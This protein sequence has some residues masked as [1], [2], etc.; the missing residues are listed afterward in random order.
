MKRKY[1]L[2]VACVALGAGAAFSQTQTGQQPGQQTA[3]QPAVRAGQQPAASVQTQ[4]RM[5]EQ[6]ASGECAQRMQRV[7]GGEFFTG[8]AAGY[9]QH[10]GVLSDLRELGHAAAGAGS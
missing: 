6:V 5:P 1:L 7:S 8:Q 4:Q 9:R 3:N 10:L 2:P